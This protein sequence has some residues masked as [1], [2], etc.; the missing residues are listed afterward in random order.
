MWRSIRAARFRV[1]QRCWIPSTKFQPT[2]RWRRR[3]PCS[4]ATK[5]KCR[6]SRRRK[7]QGCASSTE[8]PIRARY[9]IL[10]YTKKRTC[11]IARPG[12]SRLAQQ[13][14]IDEVAVLCAA[15]RSLKA[16]W[17]AL[18]AVY[19]E[20]CAPKKQSPKKQSSDASEPGTS[21]HYPGF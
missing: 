8:S 2:D 10:Q 20:G 12:A 13:Q 4:T 16:L 14:N 1:S 7:F 3:W 19:P 9:D 18:D 6:K 15:E 11:G 17:G 21:S 5:R